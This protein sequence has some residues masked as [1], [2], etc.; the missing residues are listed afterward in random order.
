[1]RKLP[2]RLI[3]FLAFIYL[4]TII[5]LAMFCLQGYLPIKFPSPGDV[6]FFGLLVALI[7][8]FT[9]VFRKISFSTSFAIHLAIFIILGPLPAI[10]IILLGFSFRILKVETSYQH[11]INTPIFV[12]FFN[13][14][15]F[16]LS[17]LYGNYF[18]HI[19]GGTYTNI[20]ITDNF[21]QL[22]VFCGIAFIVNTLVISALWSIM[23]NKNLLFAFVGNIKLGFLN[24][25]A[26]APFGIAIALIFKEYK[27]L[28]VLLVIFPIWL[29]RYTFLLYIE[30]KSQYIQTVDALMRA[31]EAR[32]KYT[33]GHSQRVGILVE[34]I[35]KELKYNQ[36]K[37]EQLHVASLL[38]D[39]GKIGIDDNILNKPG[40]LTNEEF[41]IIKNHPK[42]GFDILKDIK[43]LENVLSIVLHHHERYD[44]KGYPDGI[45]ADELGMDVFIVQLADSIDAMTT[46]RPY[47][48]AFDESQVIDEI[49]RNSGT[50]FHPVVVNAYL[51]AL[52]K[53]KKS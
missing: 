4:F 2:P 15:I 45:N 3:A 10:I 53:R 37:I 21:L 44:G 14:C 18:Y 31:M 48:K 11:I 52:Q 42:I 23:N 12:T 32:D 9:V 50:Q 28:G 30:S 5:S 17:T 25:I 26:M 13:Y 8:S 34:M 35:A 19:L 49:K 46:D 27:Y 7:E 29:V 47:R 33:E 20:D 41:S 1:M 16:T 40:K 24:I 36:W 51:N 39:V 43:N 6:F 22:I 38:H